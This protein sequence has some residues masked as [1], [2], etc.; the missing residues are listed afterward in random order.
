MSTYYIF[1][2]ELSIHF[3]TPC[4]SKFGHFAVVFRGLSLYKNAKCYLWKLLSISKWLEGHTNIS[5]GKIRFN[6]NFFWE[7]DAPLI[8]TNKQW[9]WFHEKMLSLDFPSLRSI[10]QKVQYFII[11][12]FQSKTVFYVSFFGNFLGYQCLKLSKASS[13]IYTLFSTFGN[14]KKLAPD[15]QIFILWNLAPLLGLNEL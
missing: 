8:D 14:V 10:S 2:I 12:H 6:T 5:F 15:T 4:T 3:C 7:F 1:A 11:F 9:N 13:Q